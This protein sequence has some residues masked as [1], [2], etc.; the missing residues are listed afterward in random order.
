MKMRFCL[1]TV[2]FL[3]SGTCAL[4]AQDCNIPFTQPLFGVQVE[5][6]LWYGNATR[7]NG[8]Q[9]SLRL[10]LYKPVGDGQSERPLVVVIHGGGFIEGHRNDL[11]DYCNTLAS[12]GWA[13]GT[14][15]YRLGIYG[16]GLLDPPYAYDPNEMR[17]AIYRS[18]Q[19]TKGAVRYLKGRHLQ[20]STSTTNVL[21]VGFSAGSFGAMHAAYLDQPGE[22]PAAANAIGQVQHFLTFYP[23]PDLGPVE[24]TLHLSDHDASVLGVV[25]IF[26]ALLD[27][28][29]I[30][31]PDDPALYSYHQTLDPVVGCGFQRPYW[32]I[33]LGVPD[34]YP[35][36]HGSCSIDTHMQG[37]GFA[38]GRYQF[39]LH[40]GSDHDVHDPQGVLLETLQWMRDL[41]C[42][43]N[44]SVTGFTLLEPIHIYPNPGGGLFRVERNGDGPAPYWL[45][46]A[47]GRLVHAGTLWGGTQTIDMRHLPDGVY[48]LRGVGPAVRL[49]IAR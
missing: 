34:N 41:F 44:A 4:H 43:L 20:D 12:M 22:K 45:H 6:D 16:T 19:D 49:A 1:S 26:G 24:G 28:A 31:G 32:G 8:T 46:D 42:P 21:L 37:L 25:N 33:G 40:N 10:N 48:L 30:E 5:S 2:V 38:P 14:I 47:M 17:R 36:V 9:D 23:R 3:L 39:N 11:N 7:F 29:Y 13:C 35:Y 27:I 18:M 15:S